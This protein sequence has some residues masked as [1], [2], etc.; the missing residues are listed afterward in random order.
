M[1][2]SAAGLPSCA[3]S[4]SKPAP[5]RFARLSKNQNDSGPRQ[6]DWLLAEIETRIAFLRGRRSGGRWWRGSHRASWI[7]EAHDRLCSGQCRQ[8]LVFLRS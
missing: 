3:R 8:R 7:D 4:S 5:S 6:L 2:M 1:T